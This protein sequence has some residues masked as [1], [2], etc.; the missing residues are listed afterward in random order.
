[1]GDRGRPGQHH[2]V[3][4]TTAKGREQLRIGGLLDLQRD[5]DFCRVRLDMLGDGRGIGRSADQQAGREAVA[6]A[7]FL[8]QFPSLLDVELEGLALLGV[9]RAIGTP[10]TTLARGLPL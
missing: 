10:G 2:R 3:E 9:E 7:R 4:V 8:Q 5:A 1:M 6:I